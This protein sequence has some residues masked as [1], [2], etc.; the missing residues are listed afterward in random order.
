[1]RVRDRVRASGAARQWRRIRPRHEVAW[2]GAA[3]ADRPAGHS[4]HRMGAER[5]CRHMGRTGCRSRPRCGR[6]VRLA[7][8]RFRRQVASNRLYAKLCPQC[9]RE[10][11]ITRL[12]WLLRATVGCPRHGYSL[13]WACQRCGLGIGWDRPD[14]DICRCGYP[15]RAAPAAPL[16]EGVA[17]WQSWLEARLC[18]TS[19]AIGDEKVAALPAVLAGLSL[20]GAYRIIEAMGLR[21]EPNSS[22]RG[23][24]AQHATPPRLGS[25]VDR[26]LD[27]LRAIEADPATAHRY[28]A[29]TNHQ[30]LARLAKDYSTEQD[31]LV[32]WWLMNA[33]RSDFDPGQTRAGSRPK[34]QLPLFLL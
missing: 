32:A 30:A 16:E 34:G 19:A 10:Q 11:G 26:G 25:V 13:I 21:A 2:P 8:H 18:P 9:V 4:P 5:G 14:I 7:G 23:D 17:A 3:S 28:S 12:S 24:L 29:L 20:D 1:M 31:H 33:F 6:L 27:R 22:V 15:F